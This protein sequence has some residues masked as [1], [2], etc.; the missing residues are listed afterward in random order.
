M[1]LG[2][3]LLNYN[4]SCFIPELYRNLSLRIGLETEEWIFLIVNNSENENELKEITQFRKDKNNVELINIKNEGYAKGNN[5]GMRHLFK[6]NIKYCLLVNP[7]ILFTGDNVFKCFITLVE[8]FENAVVVGPRIYDSK[9]K[10]SASFNRFSI[11]SAIYNFHKSKNSL[12]VNV[13][14]STMGC[15]LFFDL[16][17]MNS[18]DYFDENTFLYRE[19]IILAEKV[20]LR[21]FKWLETDTVSIV[22]NHIRKN[23]SI[24]TF[25]IHRFYEYQSTSY[26]FACYLNKSLF[27]IWIYKL[28]FF[29]RSVL[30]FGYTI[31]KKF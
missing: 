15:C 13:V 1:K 30:Y 24:K 25:I 16:D 6:N 12:G 7:D 28:L 27:K 10:V 19:E 9:G 18:L 14:Y 4:S 5:F 26:Y 11:F 23:G 8:N 17:K 3:L 22:H 21:N 31:I 29:A 20:L 2:V